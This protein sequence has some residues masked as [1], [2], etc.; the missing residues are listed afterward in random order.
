MSKALN[1][2]QTELDALLAKHGIQTFVVIA[3][4][5][6]NHDTMSSFD[7]DYSW[8]AGQCLFMSSLLAARWNKDRL[9]PG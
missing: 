1:D 8:I 6:D 4:D 5:P 3:R 9:T 2:F 7:G